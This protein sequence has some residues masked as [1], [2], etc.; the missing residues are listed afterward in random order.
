MSSL[1]QFRTNTERAR[2]QEMGQTRNVQVLWL[3][4]LTAPEAAWPKLE[5]TFEKVA[6]S[7]YVP[8]VPVVQSD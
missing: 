6:N 2:M 7:F 3:L 8:L 4:T 1:S 5:P